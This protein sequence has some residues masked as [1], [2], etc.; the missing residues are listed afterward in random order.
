MVL[1][2]A[3]VRRQEVVLIAERVRIRAA[4][5]DRAIQVINSP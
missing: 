1:T 2:M 3:P 4:G 5:Q